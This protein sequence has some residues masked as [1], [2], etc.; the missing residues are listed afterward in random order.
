MAILAGPW[1]RAPGV[2]T[3]AICCHYVAVSGLTCCQQ[4]ASSQ[5]C[6]PNSLVLVYGV[7]SSICQVVAAVAAAGSMQA[8][9]IALIRPGN[10]KVSCIKSS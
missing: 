4:T 6:C 8:R 2:C 10:Q 9:N 7:G 5:P 1:A 3:P